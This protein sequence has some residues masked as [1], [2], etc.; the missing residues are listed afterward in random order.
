MIVLLY[1]FLG[2]LTSAIYNEVL[3]FFLII[4]GFLPL[5]LLGLK[6]IG[7][8]NGL[9]A[10]LPVQYMHEWKGVMHASTNPM[11]IDIIGIGMG[12]G[13][14]LGSGYWCT[15]FLVIQTAMASKEHGVGAA[16]S[17][18]CG[19]SKDGLSIPGDSARAAGHRVSHAAHHNDGAQT[20]NG[21]IIHEH[22]GSSKRGGGGPRAGSGKGE[23]G[24]RQGRCLM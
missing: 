18:D 4:A 5:V 15:D 3:Q 11:G 7:G 22:H 13:F 21:V 12:L 1:I 23:P 8:W 19:G 16:R 24:H 10:A 17:A 20:V 6:N 2:G 9:K 14:V